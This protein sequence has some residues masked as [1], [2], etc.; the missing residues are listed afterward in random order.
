MTIIE[1]IKRIS[2]L[3]GRA[4]VDLADLRQATP[5]L[6][7]ADLD[8]ELLRLGTRWEI[9]LRPV[10]DATRITDR[11][12]DGLLILPDGTPIISAAV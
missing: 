9:E 10:H 1:T 7:R 3:T 11:Q 6:S 4:A 8:A 2:R 12:R 5:D